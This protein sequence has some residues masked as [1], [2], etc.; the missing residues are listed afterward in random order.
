MM[1][2][3]RTIYN[4]KCIKCDVCNPEMTVIGPIPFCTA[5]YFFEFGNNIKVDP[6]NEIYK[7]WLKKY[8]NIKY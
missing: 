8:K 2:D 3:A 5:C 4:T 1:E 7:K 6:E